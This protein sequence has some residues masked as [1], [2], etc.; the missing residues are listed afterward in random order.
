[1]PKS[2]RQGR[3]LPQNADTLTRC[4]RRRARRYL[5]TRTR[6]RGDTRGKSG[7]RKVAR[8]LTL[9]FAIVLCHWI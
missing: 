8:N 3:Y 9:D 6:P 5:Q 7:L 2:Q 1:M 4:W